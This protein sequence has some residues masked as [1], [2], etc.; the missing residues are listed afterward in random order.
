MEMHGG[1]VT[2]RSEGAG[3]GSEFTIRLPLMAASAPPTPPPADSTEED[4]A[5]PEARRRVLVIEDNAD[6]A[7]STRD[8]LELWGHDAVIART[9]VDG[10]DAALA[11]QPDLVLC[12]IS[13]EGSMSGYDVAQALRRNPA[14]ASMYLVAVTGYGMEEDQRR[15]LQAGFD[16]HVTK[17]V[18]PEALATLVQS[19]PERSPAVAVAAAAPAGG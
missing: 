9:G 19:A 2:V 1:T 5:S 10:V 8:L 17:P 4:E 18:R 13:L 3:R 6:A 12:D 14:T 16:Q 15:A 7:E 11:M